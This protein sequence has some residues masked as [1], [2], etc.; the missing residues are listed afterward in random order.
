MKRLQFKGI[1]LGIAPL[2]L[3]AGCQIIPEDPDL[4]TCEQIH[5]LAERSFRDHKFPFFVTQLHYPGD[6]RNY[7]PGR[8]VR[9]DSRQRIRVEGKDY[10]QLEELQVKLDDVK[11]QMAYR[12]RIPTS[13]C[14]N[15]Q[16]QP[17]VELIALNYRQD[18][19]DSFS[20]TTKVNLKG[21]NPDDELARM[22]CGFKNFPPITKQEKMSVLW[23]QCQTISHA[24]ETN[25]VRE[26]SN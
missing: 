13:A 14:Q 8:W 9:A 2:L 24:P 23:K 5:Y 7:H 10:M 22:T 26:T 18:E 16:T 3:L 20:E 17:E 6:W 11:K 19:P 4:M 1:C 25:R 15:A 12:I 21:Q